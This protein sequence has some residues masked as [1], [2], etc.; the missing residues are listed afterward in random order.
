MGPSP[1]DHKVLYWQNSNS[2]IYHPDKLYD[3]L[4][5][6]ISF[7]SFANRSSGMQNNNKAVIGPK[8]STVTKTTI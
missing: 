2:G 5:N 1:A 8:N 4:K 3:H 7:V 6:E